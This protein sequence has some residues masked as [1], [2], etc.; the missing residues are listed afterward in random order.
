MAVNL[1]LNNNKLKFKTY[2]IGGMFCGIAGILSICYAGSISAKMDLGSLE[3]DVSAHYFCFDWT[4][5]L[6]ISSTYFRHD[7]DR[8]IF[9]YGIGIGDDRGRLPAPMQ[10]FVTGIFMLVVMII[11]TNSAKLGKLFD[12]RK[13]LKPAQQ[14][15]RIRRGD[16]NEIYSKP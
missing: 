7:P 11:S 16:K 1:G 6:K 2:L 5:E 13:L 9:R 15:G 3:H 12:R 10:D 14:G 4:V 8:G